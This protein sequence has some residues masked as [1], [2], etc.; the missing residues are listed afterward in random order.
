MKKFL[1]FNVLCMCMVSVFVTECSGGGGAAGDKGSD[2][3]DWSSVGGVWD[4]DDGVRS[5]ELLLPALDSEDGSSGGGGAAAAQP[6]DGVDA[7]A[8]AIQDFGF[9]ENDVESQEKLT[10]LITK[11]RKE[12]EYSS[13][14][15][16]RQKIGRY[17]DKAQKIL[18]EYESCLAMEEE[19]MNA[20][21]EVVDDVAACEEIQGNLD[22][23][24]EDVERLR[25]EIDSLISSYKKMRP[26]GDEKKQL[27]FAKRARRSDDG[28]AAK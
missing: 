12:L 22:Q 15:E 20:M 19:C 7:L 26:V 28:G 27:R 1:W 5:F 4:G 6:D 11:L 17:L 21:D 10:S 9:G 14:D 13:S 8:Q 25:A 18:V 16:E 2:D 23:L 3:I 24:T